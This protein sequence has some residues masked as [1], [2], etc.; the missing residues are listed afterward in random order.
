MNIE[1]KTTL[2]DTTTG[3]TETDKKPSWILKLLKPEVVIPELKIQYAPY[4]KPVKNYQF[5]I[6]I[7]LAIISFFFTIGIIKTF[8]G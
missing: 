1:L 6:Y 7:A 4:G 3:I 8:R 2:F 5:D